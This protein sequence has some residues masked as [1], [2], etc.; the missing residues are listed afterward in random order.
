MSPIQ[1][2]NSEMAKSKPVELA[3]KFLAYMR[4]AQEFAA[5]AMTAAKIN[6]E[7][8]ANKKRD[9]VLN[10]N[11]GDKVWLKLRNIQTPQPKKN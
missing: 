1:E 7:K 9:P 2:Q 10:F 3:Q 11:V 4:E 5:A 6:M 8:N